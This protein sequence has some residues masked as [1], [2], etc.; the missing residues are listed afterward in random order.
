MSVDSYPPGLGLLAEIRI[1][2]ANFTLRVARCFTGMSGHSHL[3]FSRCQAR[4]S[5]WIARCFTGMSGLISA[6]AD[7]FPLRY[8]G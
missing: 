7:R 8:R 6:R 1:S 2:I 4:A 3:P 5:S